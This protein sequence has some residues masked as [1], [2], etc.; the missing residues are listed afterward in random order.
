MYFAESEFKNRHQNQNH[1]VRRNESDNIKLTVSELRGGG[2]RQVIVA[3]F[4][5]LCY[6]E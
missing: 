6:T 2:E 4:G 1:R 3:T 5:A